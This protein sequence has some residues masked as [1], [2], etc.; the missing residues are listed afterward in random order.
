MGRPDAKLE[1]TKDLEDF[2][3]F[4]RTGMKG[5]KGDNYYFKRYNRKRN[6]RSDE[7]QLAAVYNSVQNA[8][9][10]FCAW[11]AENE[12]SISSKIKKHRIKVRR[13]LSTTVQ[14]HVDSLDDYHSLECYLHIPHYYFIHRT[15]TK[16]TI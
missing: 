6:G 11:Y 16:Y 12:H 5:K 13:E 4:V 1:C 14:D 10:N 3:L 9:N 15:P 8:W 2:M 7:N